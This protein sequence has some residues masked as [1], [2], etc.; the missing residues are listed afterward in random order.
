MCSDGLQTRTAEVVRK[1]A[2]A[3]TAW[4]PQSNTQIKSMC[5]VMS[6][7]HTVA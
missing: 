5:P 2:D 4:F 7:Q 6:T 1:G 3:L